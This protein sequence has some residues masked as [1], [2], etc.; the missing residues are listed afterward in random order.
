MFVSIDELMT[1]IWAWSF[2]YV[3]AWLTFVCCY[4]GWSY[5]PTM[6]LFWLSLIWEDS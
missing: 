6:L 4:L 5:A 3:I 1:W 2:A